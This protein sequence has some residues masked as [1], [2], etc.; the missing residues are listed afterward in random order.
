MSCSLVP[1]GGSMASKK[2][3]GAGV[4]RQALEAMK[5][6]GLAE[7]SPG[8]PDFIAFWS[9]RGSV[10]VKDPPVSGSF[11]SPVY[12]EDVKAVRSLRKA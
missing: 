11:P 10:V 8:A 6:V 2:T 9:A 5:A 7:T 1:T 3:V 4:P 12:R